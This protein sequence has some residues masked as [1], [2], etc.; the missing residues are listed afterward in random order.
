MAYGNERVTTLD[1][2][3]QLPLSSYPFTKQYQH[4]PPH[5]LEI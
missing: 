5:Y 2:L 1:K 3:T 4:K